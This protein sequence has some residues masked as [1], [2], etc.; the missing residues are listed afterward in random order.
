MSK[1]K[2]APYWVKAFVYHNLTQFFTSNNF[3]PEFLPTIYYEGDNKHPLFFFTIIG[4]QEQY[5]SGVSTPNQLLKSI[6]NQKFISV[7]NPNTFENNNAI[8]LPNDKDCKLPIN[9][10]EYLLASKTFKKLWK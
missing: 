7:S 5:K 10:K 6:L 2:K 4:T 9:S 8:T 3:I 1:G